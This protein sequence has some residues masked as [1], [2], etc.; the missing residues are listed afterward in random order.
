MLILLLGILKLIVE[1][2]KDR[3]WRFR[4]SGFLCWWISILLAFIY[5]WRHLHSYLL[6]L[7]LSNLIKF[8][9]SYS[10]LRCKSVFNRYVTRFIFQYFLTATTNKIS[11]PHHSWF[12]LHLSLL[13]LF[14][15]LLK[16]F[17]PLFPLHE[18]IYISVYLLTLIVYVWCL[19]H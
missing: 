17:S 18:I 7:A 12:V 16:F 9:V 5:S 15:L 3:I 6:L 8:F 1:P 14:N 11:F 4:R 2:V 10:S 19:S 13:L